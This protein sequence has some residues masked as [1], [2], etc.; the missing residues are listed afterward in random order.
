MSEAKPAQSASRETLL[1]CRPEE[2]HSGLVP[3]HRCIGRSVAALYAK[4]GAD[5][6]SSTIYQL[7]VLT[8]VFMCLVAVS[9][10]MNLNTL[11]KGCDAAGLSPHAAPEQSTKRKFMGPR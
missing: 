1:D 4:E 7:L 10:T 9:T 5:I 3:S 2:L 8:V 6:T 11:E